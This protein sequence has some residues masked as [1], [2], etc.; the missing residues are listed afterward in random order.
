MPIGNNAIRVVY[1]GTADFK[2]S[3]SRSLVESVSRHGGT[4][5]RAPHPR[6]IPRG[7]AGLAGQNLLLRRHPF[8]RVTTD[9]GENGPVQVE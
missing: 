1:M 3:A 5:A 2:R 9:N 6:A 4:N 8:Q 7:S